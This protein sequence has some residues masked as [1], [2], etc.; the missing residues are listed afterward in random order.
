MIDSSVLTPT[1]L[2]SLKSSKGCPERL[3]GQHCKIF[4]DL[5]EECYKVQDLGA[6]VGTFLKCPAIELD[7]DTPG[8][9]LKQDCIVQLGANLY[10]LVNFITRR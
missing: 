2:E 3:R 4:Y 5:K 10:C 7:E 9:S 1:N 8:I 6:G